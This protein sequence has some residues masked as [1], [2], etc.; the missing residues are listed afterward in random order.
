MTYKS[1]P[2]ITLPPSQEHNFHPAYRPDIDGLRALA[3]LSVVIFHAFPKA[4]PGGFVGVDIFFVISGFLISCIIFKSLL[5]GDF[6][7]TEFYAHR[8]KRIFPALI[9]VLAACYAFGWIALLPEEFKQLGKHMAAG[10]GFV[11]NIIL[12]Q[13]SGYF[14]I[15][16]RLKPLLHLW[17]LSIEEQFYLIYPLLIWGAWR[18]RLNILIMVICTLLLISFGLNISTIGKHAVETF[19]VPQTRFWELL[20][21]SVLAYMQIF[22]LPRFTEWLKRYMFHP[23]IFQQPPPVERRNA[24]LSNLLSFGGLLLILA[25]IFGLSK[26][27]L[28]PGWWAL[29]P[30]LGAFLLILAGPTGWVNLNILANR[31]MVFVGLISYPLY[32]WHWPLLSFARIMESGKTSAIMRISI[33]ALS[34][35]LAW[36]TYRLIEKPVRFGRPSWPQDSGAV[37]VNR[38]GRV[39]RILYLQE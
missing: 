31:L 27:K 11:Q 22:K 25:A 37:P 38:S 26:G 3:I 8:I 34:F 28:F 16:S 21:G 13:E 29:A 32:L 18:L 33:I 2:K 17:S 6:S 12:W 14:D 24:I 4:L 5:R 35:L 1:T 20:A 30:V 36:L 10:A 19:F 23:M 7:F 39:Y 9:L 15:A